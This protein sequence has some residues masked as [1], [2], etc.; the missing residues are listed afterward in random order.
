M[1]DS[2]SLLKALGLESLNSDLLERALRC[3]G[4]TAGFER[5]EFLGDR[6]LG[7]AIS[8]ILLSKYPQEN[9]GMIAKRF[10]VLVQR[11]TLVIIANTL[12][13]TTFQPHLKGEELLDK[14][15]ANTVEALL[16]AIYL[17]LGFDVAKSVILSLWTTVLNAQMVPPEDPKTALQ[18]WA[19]GRGL[20]LPNYTIEDRTGPDHNPTF[21]INVHLKGHPPFEGKGQTKKEAEKEAAVAAIKFLKET[22]PKGR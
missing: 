5:L 10:S 12:S 13:V 3:H 14:S 2:S 22:P 11:E 7:L 15:K 18:E 17:D 21:T 16:G 20:P 8:D 9:E 1:V 6:V 4:D 19:Q